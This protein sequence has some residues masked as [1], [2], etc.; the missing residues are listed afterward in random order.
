MV[1]ENI[2]NTAM[3]GMIISLVISF[4]VPIGA[5]LY[6]IIKRNAKVSVFF[7]GCGVFFVFAF[8]LE[9][10]FH[11]AVAS[12]TGGAVFSNVFIT[13]IYGGLAAAAFEET[14]RLIAMKFLMKNKLTSDNAI[15]YGAG[16]GGIE[17]IITVGITEITYISIATM[18][19]A[20]QVDAIL[21]PL[22]G[23]AKE[24]MI[25][26]ISQLCST[27]S[28]IFYLA[29]IERVFAIASHIALSYFVFMAVKYGEK[30]CLMLAYGLHFLLDAST[31]IVNSL[32]NNAYI[33]ELYVLAVTAGIIYN[34]IHFKNQLN[35]DTEEE[36]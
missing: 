36:C 28:N 13:A 7:I 4:V 27:P 29:G 20:G 23:D 22:Q 2:S 26:M 19:N 15:M 25:T 12:A 16:H 3:A 34:A 1:F 33:V 14:G 24:S 35:V 17:A 9:S 32:V 6:M 8:I 10:L 31:V 21:A 11:L 5:L 18:I 30:K